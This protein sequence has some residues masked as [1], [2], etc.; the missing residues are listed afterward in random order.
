MPYIEKEQREKFDEHLKEIVK[1]IDADGELNYCIYKL[2]LMYLKR[3]GKSYFNLSRCIST[4]DCAKLEFYRKQ[5]SIYE[6]IK[7]QENGDV[8]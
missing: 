2:C 1:K 6:D 7:I 3:L 4:M 5:V 8:T